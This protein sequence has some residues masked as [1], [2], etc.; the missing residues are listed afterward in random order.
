[1]TQDEFKKETH[2]ILSDFITETENDLGDITASIKCT[3]V[4]FIM[5]TRRALN[6]VSKIN[7][8]YVTPADIIECQIQ[9]LRRCVTDLSQHEGFI[10]NHK[11]GLQ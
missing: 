4:Q 2:K 11:E 5:N 8:G 3:M 1:M 9:E 6:I 7:G 10:K